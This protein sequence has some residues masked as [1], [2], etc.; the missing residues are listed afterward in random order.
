M[1]YY[2]H[3]PL[4]VN[5]FRH[6]STWSWKVFYYIYWEISCYLIYTVLTASY[7][8]LPMH[9]SSLLDVKTGFAQFTETI[10]G[11]KPSNH[12]ASFGMQ[13]WPINRASDLQ[14]CLLLGNNGNGEQKTR[15]FTPSVGVYKLCHCHFS[16]KISVCLSWLTVICTF[17]THCTLKWCLITS[18]DC[19]TRCVKYEFFIF[20]KLFQS[21]KGKL[22]CFPEQLLL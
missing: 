21:F 11:F 7:T 1:L 3:K 19:L 8:A 2:C 9:F 15:T 14:F 18:S 6:A 4:F 20:L 17:L 16:S 10:V 5:P 22:Q 13:R 12:P